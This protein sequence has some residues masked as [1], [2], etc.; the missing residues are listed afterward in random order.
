MRQL[1]GQ[2]KSLLISAQMFTLITNDTS[3]ISTAKRW[4]CI[5]E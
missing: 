5:K 1:I 3:Q 4:Q 2:Q